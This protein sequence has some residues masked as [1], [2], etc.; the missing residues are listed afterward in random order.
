MAGTSVCRFKSFKSELRTPTRPQPKVRRVKLS[1]LA[2]TIVTE[3]DA[4]TLC[5]AANQSYYAGH[6]GK[7]LSLKFTLN[8][9]FCVISVEGMGAADTARRNEKDSLC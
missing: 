4:A 5:Y 1:H 7:W 6:N 3:A 2:T 9:N 8:I